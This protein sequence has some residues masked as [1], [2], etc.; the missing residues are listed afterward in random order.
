MY[1]VS[2]E[3]TKLHKWVVPENLLAVDEIASVLLTYSHEKFRLNVLVLNSKFFLLIVLQFLLFLG[4]IFSFLTLIK[5]IRIRYLVVYLHLRVKFF[6]EYILSR[7]IIYNK[8][9]IT[10]C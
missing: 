8:N 7:A 6:Q 10:L 5:A 4:A 2:L 3:R 9:S 1:R